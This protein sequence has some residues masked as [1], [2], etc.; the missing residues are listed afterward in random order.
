MEAIVT[1]FVAVFLASWGDKTQLIVA[2]LAARSGRPVLVLAGLLVAALAS[3]LVAAWAGALIGATLPPR[4]A[5]LMIALAL[6]LG[7]LGAFLPRAAPSLGSMKLPLLLVTAIL[8]LATETGSRGQFLSFALAARFDSVW[9]A[10]AGASAGL[11]A[12]SVPAALL[13]DRLAK[14]VPMRAIRYVI[15]GLF[16]VIGFIVAMQALRLA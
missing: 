11:F 9:L 5:S 8:C 10:M 16:L 4:A 6:L 12:A 13:G 7:G 15:G 3:H 1:T 2:L 14:A